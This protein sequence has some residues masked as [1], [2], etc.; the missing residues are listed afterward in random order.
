M[1]RARW[2]TQPSL[3]PQLRLLLPSLLQGYREATACT[4]RAWV[5]RTATVALLRVCRHPALTQYPTTS[6]PG[7]TLLVLGQG[8]WLLQQQ[9]G[10]RRLT[11]WVMACLSR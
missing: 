9:Q 11:S 4:P 6:I 10:L 5:A 1:Q 2:Q 3:P 7:Q 8:L